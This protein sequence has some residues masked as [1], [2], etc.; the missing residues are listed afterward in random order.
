MFR[1]RTVYIAGG[2]WALASA[3]FFAAGGQR[4]LPPGSDAGNTFL[5]I[6][7]VIE[8]AVMAFAIWQ[9]VH[10]ALSRPPA[11]E[12]RRRRKVRWSLVLAGF[13]AFGVGEY[14]VYHDDGT[15]RQST[16]GDRRSVSA[17]DRLDAELFDDG[18]LDLKRNG[19]VVWVE[20]LQRG[21]RGGSYLRTL[22]GRTIVDDASGD[23]IGA[24]TT[25][26]FK[27]PDA[28]A[29]VFTADRELR[30]PT[31]KRDLPAIA[32]AVQSDARLLNEPVTPWTGE[33][34]IHYGTRT[35]IKKDW[36]DGEIV[37]VDW[38]SGGWAGEAGQAYL[39]IVNG[40]M[41]SS[42]DGVFMLV[43]ARYEIMAGTVFEIK[44]PSLSAE[45]HTARTSFHIAKSG[46]PPIGDIQVFV[47][48]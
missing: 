21:E 30:V 14:F 27:A 25:F 15:A 47:V 48:K 6:A 24:G 20:W 23:Q 29:R 16:L 39:R 41:I 36:S 31:G 32:K 35:E 4:F 33:I 26:V 7:V 44:V 17:P 13:V 1:A 28:P 3:L 22:G 34:A 46:W 40:R 43:G 12:T 37:E 9:V 8:G 38:A 42:S 18:A 2:V 5:T 11:V 45:R 19:K 10:W